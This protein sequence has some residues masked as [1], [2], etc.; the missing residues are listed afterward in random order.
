MDHSTIP[1]LNFEKKSA[2]TSQR[3]SKACDRLTK[4]QLQPYK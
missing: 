1:K 4:V 3:A 2:Q